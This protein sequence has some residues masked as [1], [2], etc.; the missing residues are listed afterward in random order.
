MKATWLPVRNTT[1]HRSP[2]ECQLLFWMCCPDSEGHVV[3]AEWGRRCHW[4]I[5]PGVDQPYD[6]NPGTVLGH[7]SLWAPW[8]PS[9]TTLCCTPLTVL[10]ELAMSSGHAGW[11]KEGIKQSRYECCSL[12]PCSET[13]WG[14][15]KLSPVLQEKANNQFVVHKCTREWAGGVCVDMR[16]NEEG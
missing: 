4:G 6:I 11:S 12:C 1:A 15:A 5:H 8:D 14:A 9:G 2:N 16:I 13:P 7:G 10:R 3:T